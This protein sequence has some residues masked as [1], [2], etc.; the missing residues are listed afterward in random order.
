MAWGVDAEIREGLARL[1]EGS[2]AITAP[3]VGDVQARR[4]LIEGL[5][6]R[7]MALRPRPSDVTTTDTY[8]KTSD[9]SKILLRWYV[10]TGGS[11]GAA[12]LFIH[13]GGMIL[14]SVSLY[15]SLAARYCAE[16]GVRILAVDYRYAPE[17]PYPTPQE[18][19]YQ[20]LVWLRTNAASLGIDPARLAVMGDSAGGGLAASVALMARDRGGPQL[21]RQILIYPMIDDR[22]TGPDPRLRGITTWNYRDNAT[23]WAALLGTAAG[24]DEVS[25]YAA[26]AR[27]EDLAGLAA[28]YVEVGELDIFRGE[29]LS[30]AGRLSA[31]GVSTE[32]H[33]HPG[34]PHGYDIF[35]PECAV[36]QRAWCDRIRVLHAL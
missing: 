5:L 35:V 12:A 20:A 25:P 31:A 9:G 32:L 8:L 19:C 29:A 1:Y 11:T 17:H 24:T 13:G 7:A 30:Y 36:T 18:D 3:A 23:G 14:G 22:T 26:P 16:S 33:V 6:G 21:A 2:P 34:A 28:A 27:C 15:D 4:T 10:P